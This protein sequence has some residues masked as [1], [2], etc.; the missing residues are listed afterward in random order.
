MTDY[1]HAMTAYNHIDTQDHVKKWDIKITPSHNTYTIPLLFVLQIKYNLEKD[2][3]L[4]IISMTQ[5]VYINSLLEL[6]QQIPVSSMLRLAKQSIP[7]GQNM[8]S[9]VYYWK[10]NTRF[11]YC[12]YPTLKPLHLY[13]YT[14]LG[15][16]GG[17]P[18]RTYHQ[19]PC[20]VIGMLEVHMLR[21]QYSMDPN[22]H[23]RKTSG[24]EWVQIR[25]LFDSDQYE[26]HKYFLKAMFCFQSAIIVHPTP[27]KGKRCRTIDSRFIY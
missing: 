26:Y 23:Y 13:D 3:L 6:H 4:Y 24:P 19:V 25:E 7:G 8:F 12:R 1:V 21:F 20:Y 16:L 17:A 15:L 27:A 14:D 9:S 5:M 11:S 22:H 2:I 10:Y 18:P